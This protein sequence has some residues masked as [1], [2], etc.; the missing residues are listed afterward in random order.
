MQA[1]QLPLNNCAS[2]LFRF[3]FKLP[4]VHSAFEE[5]LIDISNVTFKTFCGELCDVHSLKYLELR[6]YS[7]LLILGG[8]HTPYMST[9]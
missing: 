5:V 8:F 2:F 4:H 7:H 1:L 9:C 3:P 6:N